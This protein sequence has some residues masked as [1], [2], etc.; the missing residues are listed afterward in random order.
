MK[1]KSIILLFSIIVFLS[2]P[3]YSADYSKIIDSLKQVNSKK[4]LPTNVKAKT[5]YNLSWYYYASQL[6]DSSILY[7]KQ[8]LQYAIDN[9]I[10]TVVH[11]SAVILGAVFTIKNEND[12]SYLYLHKGASYIE[13]NK[14]TNCE[15]GLAK[16]YSI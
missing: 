2:N 1:S 10:D 3:I 14:R 8:A 11:K 13:S 7:S 5:L 16:I 6:Y 9:N 15:D 12:S 4:N